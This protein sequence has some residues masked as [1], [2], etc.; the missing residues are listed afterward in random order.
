MAL[1]HFTYFFLLLLYLIIPV[2]LRLRKK[3]SFAAGLKNMLP[4]VAFSTAIF[5]M[6]DIRF[7]EL[8][9]W[10][11]NPDY[12]P[13]VEIAHV[14][15]EEWISFII[16]PLSAFYIYE[17]LKL[18]IGTFAKANLFVVVSLVVFAATA[19]GAFVF[20][21]RMFSFFTFFLT[22]IYLGYTVF[23]NRFKQ[24][25]TRF[26]LAFFI[27]LLPFLLVSF[28]QN[29]LPVVVY[30]EAHVTGFGLPG[31]PVEKI[32]YLFLMLLIN[33]T[34]FEYLNERRLF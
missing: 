20:R 10:S 34:V 26:Y 9:I 32:V 16:I 25:Y 17:W 4:A 7:T 12:M 18:H 8:G 27:T 29:N 3:I 13:G 1:K 14:P 21:T 19:A 11:F 30:N 5:G 22:A 31:V 23:R 2:L 6:W 28:I 33:T 15:L 24:H